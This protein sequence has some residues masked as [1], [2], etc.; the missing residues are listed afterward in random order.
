LIELDPKYV[1]V[2]VS[3]WQ[4]TTQLQAYH[5]DTERKFGPIEGPVCEAL[6]S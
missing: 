6:A 4:Q 2:I 5:A 1:D 3:R